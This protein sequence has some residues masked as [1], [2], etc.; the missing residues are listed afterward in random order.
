MICMTKQHFDLEA[1][2][3]WYSGNVHVD[4]DF[5]ASVDIEVCDTDVVRMELKALLESNPFTTE[6]TIHKYFMQKFESSM[7]EDFGDYVACED[8][9]PPVA[10]DYDINFEDLALAL[11][12]HYGFKL[13]SCECEGETS[14]Y[15]PN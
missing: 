13:I 9:Y 2:D 1:H 10:E 7:S 12:R 14:D 5:Y 11:C 3:V 6:E 4:A 8:Y 15:I